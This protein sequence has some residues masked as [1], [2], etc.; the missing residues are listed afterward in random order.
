M[1]VG[2][3]IRAPDLPASRSIR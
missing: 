3:D 2:S 1:I